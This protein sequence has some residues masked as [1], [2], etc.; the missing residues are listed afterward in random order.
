MSHRICDFKQNQ[1][2]IGHLDGYLN[3]SNLQTG[4]YPIDV[5]NMVVIE[6]RLTSFLTTSCFF[7]I[8]RVGA[9]AAAHLLT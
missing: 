5:K 1:A 3:L 7:H 2:E 8:H 9:D 6:N 4:K